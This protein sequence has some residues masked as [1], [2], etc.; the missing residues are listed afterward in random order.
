MLDAFA[1]W[2]VYDALNL[3]AGRAAAGLQFFVYETIKIGLLLL[4]VTHFMGWINAVFPVERVRSLI[5]SGKL[6]G[7]EHLAASF[8]GAATPFCSC[9]SIPL[10][11]GFLQGGIPLG[12][13]LSFLITSPLVN[14]VALALFLGTFGLRVTLVYAASGILLG[15]VLGWALGRMQLE[16]QVEEWVWAV[17]AQRISE[18]SIERPPLKERMSA[19][20]REAFGI[21][22]RIGP[23]VVAGVAVG[24]F[25]HG[26]VPTDFFAA[27][28]STSNPF[29]VPLSVILAVPMYASASGVVP[30]VQA[31][32]AKG[33]PLGTAMAFMMGVVGLSMP[34]ALML[35]K[36][37]H[38]R[39]LG[40]FFGA[41]SVSIIALG[42]FFNAVL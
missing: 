9:S 1:G 34:E 10:F 36:V 3:A 22:K 13:T 14:E 42:Y 17:A 16:G 18:T 35:K 40:V 37:M 27:Y 26:Y 4:L 33:I 20:S 21:V 19:I 30:I 11:I 8:F 12:V 6:R 15:T 31:L 2:L 24:A 38:L 28:V 41:V 29:A 25:I 7:A 39:L 5:M 23:Y 32:V